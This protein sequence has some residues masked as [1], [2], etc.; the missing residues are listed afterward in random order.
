MSFG[1]SVGL[2]V[3]TA[4]E[5]SLRQ[6]RPIRYRARNNL[7]SA[8]LALSADC[9]SNPL[10]V[11]KRRDVQSAIEATMTLVKESFSS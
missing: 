1:T 7:P 11:A 10:E 6:D 4:W 2:H 9:A 8:S 3:A 5:H